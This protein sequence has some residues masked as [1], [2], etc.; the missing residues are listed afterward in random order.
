VIKNWDLLVSGPEFAIATM[1]RAL[2]CEW[3]GM[4]SI[5]ASDAKAKDSDYNG[6]PARVENGRKVIPLK[7]SEFHL[8][9]VC[10][11]LIG[12]LCR[13]RLGHQPES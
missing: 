11:R 8:R 13:C 2:N 10:P 4:M 5:G 6:A 7:W 12:R 3:E 1:P 9:K